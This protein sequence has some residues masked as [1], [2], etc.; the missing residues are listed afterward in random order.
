MFP[1][2][3]SA[4]A[5]ALE[6]GNHHATSSIVATS[7]SKAGKMV[8][9]TGTKRMPLLDERHIQHLPELR[10]QQPSKC[11]VAKLGSRRV[12]GISDHEG[13]SSFRSGSGTDKKFSKLLSCWLLRSKGSVSSV[14]GFHLGLGRCFF[15]R[16]I[17][18][19]ESSVDAF[20]KHRASYFSR[21][22]R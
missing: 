16:F 9:E 20:K 10:R 15:Y 7:K 5:V 4:I 8:A 11:L 14:E 2:S 22:R 21:P 17:Q 12:K 18:N 6:G 13:G 3:C 1:R 19:V